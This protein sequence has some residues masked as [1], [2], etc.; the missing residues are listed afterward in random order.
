MCLHPL[1]LVTKSLWQQH[2]TTHA[3]FQRRV[4]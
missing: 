3:P 2:T 1:P 4:Q